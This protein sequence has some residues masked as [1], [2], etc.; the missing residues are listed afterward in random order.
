MLG[1]AWGSLRMGIIWYGRE[2]DLYHCDGPDE[3]P[4]GRGVLVD[5][6]GDEVGG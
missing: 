6:L 5:D 4:R 1:H 3:D 2:E